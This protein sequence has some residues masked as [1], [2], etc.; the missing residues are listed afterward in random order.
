[1]ALN[2]LNPPLAKLTGAA[3]HFGRLSQQPEFDHLDGGRDELMNHILWF[4][5]K[6]RLPYPAALAGKAGADD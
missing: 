4:A 2:T 1:M 5:T 3:R 6:G